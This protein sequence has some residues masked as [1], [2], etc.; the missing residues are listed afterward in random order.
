MA[1]TL[2]NAYAG[3]KAIALSAGIEPVKALNVVAI[4]A[5]KEA[6]YD[7]SMQRPKLI[8]DTMIDSADR[9]ITMGCMDDESCPAVITDQDWG[10]D[11]PAGAPIAKVRE[12]R[13]EIARRVRTLL[14]EL[15]IEPIR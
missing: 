13:D 8:T 11:D 7:M 3:G 9:V 10:L 2:F 6:G 14:R 4:A 12:I 5:M 1:E 15:G